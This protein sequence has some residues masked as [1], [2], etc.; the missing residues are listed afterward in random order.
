MP[1]KS[2]EINVDVA[3]IGGGAA[4]FFSAIHA[5][6]T[7]NT[8]AIFEKSSKILSKVKVSGGGRCNVTNACFD[9]DQ[10]SKSYPRGARQLKRAFYQFNAQSTIDWFESR[11]VQ[12]KTQADNRVFP[13]SDVSQSI[14]DCLFSET[15]KKDI[16]LFLNTSILSIEKKDDYFILSTTDKTIITNKVILAT[17]GQPKASAYTSL[18]ELGLKI[19]SPTPSL[20]TFNMPNNPIC[21]L[22]GNS[23][24]NATVKIEGTKLIAKGALL[25]THWGMS[26]PAVL[27]LSAWGARVLAEKNYHF[28]IIVNWLNDTTENELKENFLH[29]KNE[30]PD[31]LISNTNPYFLSSKIWHFIL[32]KYDISKQLKWKELEGKKL[33]KLVSSLLYDKYEVAGKTTFKEE[34]VTCGGVDLLEID[35][36]TMESKKIKGLYLIGELIDIDGITGGFNFQAAWTTG[37]IAG[38]SAGINTI[39]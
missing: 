25:I 20:F 37:F 5:K 3:V 10:L 6:T 23:V 9:N 19:V 15:Q 2:N 36:N 22:M 31:K 18:E 33:N 27:E 34:F 29:L 39:K 21:K 28:S 4:G 24:T 11:G 38:K 14:I 8:V 16:D 12:L 26:G 35:F 17:G 7:T 30:S 32:D 13:V 1:S